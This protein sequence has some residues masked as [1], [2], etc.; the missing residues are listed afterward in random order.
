RLLAHTTTL[1]YET[2][3]A[4]AWFLSKKCL[5]SGASDIPPPRSLR[6][7]VEPRTLRQ[8]GRRGALALLDELNS[9]RAR[10]RRFED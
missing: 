7:G 5:V 10:L 4:T 8:L 9:L 3:Q 6:L 1:K 2:T